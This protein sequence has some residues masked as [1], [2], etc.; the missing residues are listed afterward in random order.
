[1][2]GFA[3]IRLANFTFLSLICGL[4]LFSHTLFA[5]PLIGEGTAKT[6]EDAR[7]NALAILSQQILVDVDSSTSSQTIVKQDDVEKTAETSVALTSDIKFQ[8]VEFKS[9]KKRKIWHVQA[10]LSDNALRQ[11]I[12]F[13]AERL[14]DD[15]EGLT[16]LQ[17]S[18]SFYETR[19]LQALF[20]FAAQKNIS[21][22]DQN[23][24]IQHMT[25]NLQQLQLRLGNYGW[26]RFILPKGVAFDNRFT[27]TIDQK[28]FDAASKIFLPVGD[29]RYN[30]ARDN[31]ATEQ[32]VLRISRGREERI[33]LSLVRL[34]ATTPSIALDIDAPDT[35]AE[36][37]LARNLQEVLIN[38]GMAIDN[39]SPLIL[40]V[41]AGVTPNNSVK[42]FEHLLVNLQLSFK[43]DQR[44]IASDSQN[45]RLFDIE[46]GKVSN[47][48]WQILSK[49]TLLALFSGDGLVK[50]AD[51]K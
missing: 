21:V 22:P 15:I 37:A 6:E 12:L 31:Y 27:I 44:I 51:G 9:D 40:E 47:Y 50:I 4:L 19:Q 30:I 14:P 28:E 36:R 42:D 43:R 34:P 3:T 39:K 24:I 29:F 35:Q 7:K 11:T 49:K 16:K 23:N 18:D 17:L 2:R 32:G 10:I 26:V 8:G 33:A 41:T 13:L 45:I 46:Q 38:Y 5:A 25:R 20:S 1:M 48:Q